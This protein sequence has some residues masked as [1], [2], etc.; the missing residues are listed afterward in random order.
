MKT[1]E[2]PGC[3]LEAPAD[4]AVCPYCGYEFPGARAGTRSAAWLMVLLL[5]LF[6]VPLLAWLLS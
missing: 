1:R 5:V 4:A 2:C 3:A 6:A